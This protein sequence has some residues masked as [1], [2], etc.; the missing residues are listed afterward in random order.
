L[1]KWIIKNKENKPDYKD[2]LDQSK[3]D[4]GLAFPDNLIPNKNWTDADWERF[5]A[6]EDEEERPPRFPRWVLS[7]L[8]FFVL[9]GFIAISLPVLSPLLFD[10]MDYLN[11]NI[12]LSQ[13]PLVEKAR[14]AVVGIAVVGNKVGNQ[15]TGTGFGVTEDGWILTNMHVVKDASSIKVT[16]ENGQ[17]YYAAD[18][19][20]LKAYDIAAVKIKAQDLPCLNINQQFAAE[21]GDQLTIVGNPLGFMRIATRGPVL[22]VHKYQATDKGGMLEMAV[23]IR[24]GSSGSPMID[25]NGEAVGIIFGL[26]EIKVGEKQVNKELGLAFDLVMGELITLG[27]VEPEA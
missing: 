2:T 11:Q 13:E 25:V 20:Q 10:N 27:I 22:A 21:P 23:A 16:L 4:T 1:G 18:Y 24:P 3:E 12:E 6:D 15:R 9:V 14:Q 26:G 8:A 7:V 19:Q 17:E 5:F